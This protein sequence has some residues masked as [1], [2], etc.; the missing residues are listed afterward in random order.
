MSQGINPVAPH[1]HDMINIGRA[2][3][4]WIVIIFVET[5]H[6]ILRTLFLQPL[7]GDFR[8]RQIGVFVGAAL[9]LAVAYAF[10]PWLHVQGRRL[11]IGIG[12]LWVALTIVFEAALGRIALGLSWER[13][14]SDYDFSHGG[15]MFFGLMFLG[16]SPLIAARLR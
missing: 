9:I 14:L 12:L 1:I 8:A 6:G 11:L 16:A 10:S 4:V 5:V 15:L 2:F 3:L 13:I 7:V